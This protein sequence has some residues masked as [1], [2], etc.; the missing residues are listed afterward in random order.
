MVFYYFPT[1]DDL[2]LAVVE[3]VYAGL[4]E[5]LGRALAPDVSVRER[6]ERAFLRLG[7]ASDDELEVVR[8][9]AREALVSSERFGRVLS[10]AQRGHLGMLLGTLREGVERGEIDGSLSLPLLLVAT[11]GLGALPQMVR[12]ASAGRATPLSSLPAAPELARTSVELLFRAIG[13]GKRVA[14]A[15]RRAKKR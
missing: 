11:L 1:K 3:Q 4:L 12:R 10:R 9:V 6:L 13:A 2:F 5:D 7:S 14:P 8:L 15:A